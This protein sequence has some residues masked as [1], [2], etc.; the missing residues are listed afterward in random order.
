[1]SSTIDYFGR[2]MELRHAKSSG[3]NLFYYTIKVNDKNWELTIHNSYHI[4]RMTIADNIGNL[5]KYFQDLIRVKYYGNVV[6]EVPTT[7]GARTFGIYYTGKHPETDAEMETPLFRISHMYIPLVNKKEINFIYRF[8]EDI[9]DAM[10]EYEGRSGN[11]PSG[12]YVNPLVTLKTGKFLEM[13][14]TVPRVNGTEGA[15][16]TVSLG[17][18]HLIGMIPMLRAA[19]SEQFDL[20][21]GFRISGKNFDNMLVQDSVYSGW[22]FCSVTYD[23]AIGR[24]KFHIHDCMLLD[25]AAALEKLIKAEANWAEVVLKGE[26]YDTAIFTNGEKTCKLSELESMIACN[27][28]KA[29][30]TKTSETKVETKDEKIEKPEI[31]SETLKAEPAK[32]EAIKGPSGAAPMSKHCLRLLDVLEY[33]VHMPVLTQFE[34][35]RLSRD[36]LESWIEAMPDA[37]RVAVL[38]KC[39]IHQLKPEPK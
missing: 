20:S 1:M 23:G 32:S 24:N 12:S 14:I 31:K 36:D 25:V 5:I 17:Y 39:V 10:I 18:Y 27:W 29:E 38:S 35:Q 4:V 6:V 11:A 22:T 7:N 16:Q 26:F 15:I 30:E 9:Y 3:D 8:L 37:G 28:V 21:A 19:A 2:A 13:K 34:G 33:P